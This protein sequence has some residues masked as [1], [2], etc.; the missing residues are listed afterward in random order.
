MRQFFARL[1]VQIALL[2]SALFVL[3]VLFYTGYTVTEQTSLAEQIVSRQ[4]R[5]SALSMVDLLADKMAANDGAGVEFALLQLAENP[6]IRRLALVGSD[7]KVVSSIRKD[8]ASAIPV[9]DYS[10]ARMALPEAAVPYLERSP[11]P[12]FGGGSR[13]QILWQPLLPGG[14]MRGWLRMEVSLE[15]LALAQ[16]HIWED[17]VIAIAVAVLLSTL[18]LLLFLSRPLRALR[19]A[20]EFAARLDSSRG[21]QI[22]GYRGNREIRALVMALNRASRKLKTQEDLIEG[23]NRF[24]TGLTDALGQGVV[25]TDAQGCCTFVNAEAA[26]L[27]GWRRQEMLGANLHDL[28]HYQTSNGV[29]VSRDECAMHAEVAAAHVYRSDFDAFSRK[30]GSLFPI[31]VVQVPLFEGEHVI[32]SVTAFQDITERRHNED[33]LLASTSRLS[34]LIESLQAGVLVEDENRQIVLVNQALG[35]QLGYEADPQELIGLDGRQ[36]IRHLQDAFAEPTAFAERVAA[37]VDGRQL[38]IGEELVLADG[39]VLERDYIP[40]YLFPEVAA[41]DDY[42]GHLWLYRDITERKRFEGELKQARDAAES[43]NRTKSEFLANMSHEIRTPMNGIIGM[44]DLALGTELSN[45]QRDYLDMVKSS[46]ESLLTIINDILDFSKIEAGRLDIE[47]IHFPLAGLLSDIVKPLSLRA[48]QKQLDL[49]LE[50]DDDLPTHIVA[51]P[52]RLR[53]VLINLIG[54]AIKFTEAGSISLQVKNT[55]TPGMLHFA[56]S[57]TGIGIPADKQNLI[58]GAFSQADNSISRRY[59]GTGLGL[60]ICARLVEL[61]GGRLWVES[62]GVSGSAFHFTIAVDRPVQGQLLDSGAGGQP[63]A[64]PEIH[65]RPLDIL[66]AEDNAINQRIVLALL[67]NQGHRVSLASDGSEA[68][69]RLAERGFD[70]VLMDMQMPVLDGIGATRAIRDLERDA[71]SRWPGRLPI[72]AMTANAMAGDRERC[73]DAGMDG[74]I[75]KPIRPEEL[76]AAMAAAL[77]AARVSTGPLAAAAGAPP[78]VAAAVYDRAAA[79][80]QIGGDAKLFK[81]IADMFIGEAPDYCQ[82]LN[83]ALAAADGPLLSREAHTLKSLFGTFC[84]SY[85]QALALEVEQR[86]KKEPLAAV[87]PLVAEV[88]AEIARLAEALAA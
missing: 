13:A 60:S 37:V 5:A 9:A 26:H 33:S 11:S 74:Y 3:T 71:D 41:A 47:H 42:R 44:T 2:V 40:I 68:L 82:R 12:L 55:V 66:V 64:S 61:M 73:L 85:G 78:V 57:D 65:L 59:G 30:D 77:P 80:A 18:V 24:L 6:D 31:A 79:L 21:E 34:A 25:A 14:T 32:G 22:P 70:L 52:G 46:A 81:V 58:F 28:V 43:A 63:D 53:Q 7:G 27:L 84:A 49:H 10:L 72:I 1:N 76:F 67:G 86:L 75:A 35:R 39:R 56:V 19:R 29:P 62:D 45:Q 88:Q 87:A 69:A 50:A 51:D 4:M 54:N 38:V 17:S 23:N 48:R 16:R 36:V 8:A 20:T 15:Q 83:D